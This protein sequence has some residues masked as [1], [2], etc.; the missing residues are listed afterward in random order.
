M[1][2]NKNCMPYIPS[3]ISRSLVLPAGMSF[4]VLPDF[5]GT[6]GGDYTYV[7]DF[8]LNILLFKPTNLQTFTPYLTQTCSCSPK[9]LFLIFANHTYYSHILAIFGLFLYLYLKCI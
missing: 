2:I 5:V 3:Q 6:G 1:S 9:S 7:I 8:F 4:Y